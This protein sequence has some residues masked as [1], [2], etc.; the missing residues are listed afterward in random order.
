[1][2]YRSIGIATVVVISATIAL[3]L[4]DLFR[5]LRGAAV[6]IALVFII[7]GTFNTWTVV[8]ERDGQKNSSK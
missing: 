8:R 1:M 5:G 6:I 4:W 7:G 2:K 3:G